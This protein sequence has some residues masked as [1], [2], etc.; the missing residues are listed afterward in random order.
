MLLVVRLKTQLK[1]VEAERKRFEAE[2]NRL[3]RINLENNNSGPEFCLSS[4]L[5]AV[6]L[7]RLALKDNI[8]SSAVCKTW[9]EIAASVRVRLPPCWLMYL[10]QCRNSYGFFDPVEKK[11]KKTKAVMNLPELS[12]SCYILYSNDGWLLM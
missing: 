8:R 4:D 10:D 12:K 7:S 2:V 11:K 6:V 9:G 5:L 3:R 1:K